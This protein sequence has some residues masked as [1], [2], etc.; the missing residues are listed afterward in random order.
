MGESLMTSKIVPG[1]KHKQHM[2]VVDH[3][4]GM[5]HLG[6]SCSR[7]H[8]AVLAA[9]DLTLLTGGKLMIQPWCV[10]YLHGGVS[11]NMSREYI[12]I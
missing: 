6:C 7:S 9:R 8:C 3:V 12:D 5:A 11:C 4:E 1:Q 2:K 10:P